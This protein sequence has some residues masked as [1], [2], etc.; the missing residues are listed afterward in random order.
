[1][2]SGLERRAQALVPELIPTPQDIDATGPLTAREH[3][4]LDRCEQARD[5]GAELD[6][7]RGKALQAIQQRRLY[8]EGGRTFAAY[9]EEE[10]GL[11]ESAAYQW[12]EEWPLA[13]EISKILERPPVRSHV[14]ALVGY[15][16]EHGAEETA[17]DYA[18]AHRRAQAAGQ[19]ITAS[20]L[21]TWLSGDETTRAPLAQADWTALPPAP[22]PA[23]EPAAP[24][25]LTLVPPPPAAPERP[26]AGQAESPAAVPVLENVVAAGI[27]DDAEDQEQPDAH[28]FAARTESKAA[29]VLAWAINEAGR[30]GMSLRAVLDA[31][32]GAVEDQGTP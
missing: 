1:M 12:I 27:D 31:L 23:P 13:A 18:T 20:K 17:A 25:P 7:M 5:Q 9:V 28:A 16:R 6:W 22:A 4:D 10:W 26:T 2:V 24:A 19:R 11:T 21:T 32:Y 15:A 3:R 8:R 30:M 29:D 14:R